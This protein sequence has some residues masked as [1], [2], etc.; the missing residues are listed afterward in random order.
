M[1]EQIS[2]IKNIKISSIME[3]FL[4]DIVTLITDEQGFILYINDDY[5]NI[6]DV[7]PEEAK[8]KYCCDIIPGTRMHIVAKTKMKELGVPFRM[9]NG[10]YAVIDRFPICENDHVVG[11]VCIVLFSTEVLTTEKALNLANNLRD[12]LLHYKTALKE[13]RGAKYSVDNIIGDTRVMRSVKEGINNVAQT[14]STILISGE[15]G[16][17]KELFAHAIHQLS[18]RCHQPLITVNCAAIPPDLFESELFGYVEGAFTGAR[19]GGSPGKFEQ[20]NK[21]TLVLDEI[22]LLPLQMQPKLLRVLQEREVERVGSGRS[23]TID[24]RMIFI[25][26][27]NL[28][29]LVERGEFRED[30][31]Y[32]INI[33]PIDIPPLRDR[34]DDIATL[35]N[36]LLRK[37]NRNLGLKIAGVDGD[38]LDLFALHDWPGNVRELEHLLE[39][40]AN[41]RLSGQLSLECF[42]GLRTRLQAAMYQEPPKNTI[43]AV[44]RHAEREKIVEAL[45]L[46]NGNISAAGKQLGMSRSNIYEKIKKYS[47]NFDKTVI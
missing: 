31:F 38:V 36:Y 8:G 1:P 12:E 2:N 23:I 41:M 24:V 14:R 34:K 7:K 47:I 20:A 29:Q 10:E 39:R 27:K 19:K 11:V 30:L 13:L 46:A 18:P 15:T 25:T 45:K 43:T 42:D 44:K 33:V 3:Q 40:A 17:G 28:K 26:N 32:R 5:A 6:I 9:K 16:T 35:V 22:H 37:I 4:N 21:G